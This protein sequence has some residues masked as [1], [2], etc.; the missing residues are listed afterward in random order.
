MQKLSIGPILMS[1]LIELLRFHVEYVSMIKPSELEI[2][3]RKIKK[4]HIEGY[5]RYGAFDPPRRDSISVTS[6]TFLTI[7]SHSSYHYVEIKKRFGTCSC[8]STLAFES[9]IGFLRQML[10]KHK[11]RHPSQVFLLKRFYENIS[12]EDIAKQSKLKFNS[13]PGE[14]SLH[15]L[16]VG[17][18]EEIIAKQGLVSFL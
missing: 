2:L 4:V 1:Q 7:N 17:S 3:N 15:G 14:F 12:I 8:F 6:A 18:L 13:A 9:L 5:K 16:K 11:S 10:D